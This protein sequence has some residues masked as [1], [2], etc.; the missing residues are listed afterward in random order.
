MDTLPDEL[1]REILIP[2]LHIDEKTFECVFAR[3]PF[4][5]LLQSSSVLL[6]VCKTWMRVATPLLYNT[7]ILRSKAQAYALQRTLRA[8]KRFGSY[9]RK[10]R[11]EGGYG[12]AMKTIL[13]LAPKITHIWLTLDLSGGDNTTGLCNS[14]ALINPERV[15]LQDLSTTRITAPSQKLHT[16]LCDSFKVWTNMVC[17]PIPSVWESYKKNLQRHISLP[18]GWD[19]CYRYLTAFVNNLVGVQNLETIDVNES[20]IF[21]DL[22]TLAKIP[23]L[24]SILIR[25]YKPT[26]ENLAVFEEH[27]TSITRGFSQPPLKFYWDIEDL[28]DID[29]TSEITPVHDSL[30]LPSCGPVSTASKKK[31]ELA[32]PL[33]LRYIIDVN[34]T[35]H[36]NPYEMNETRLAIS[37]V[38]KLFRSLTRS[39]IYTSPIPLQGKGIMKFAKR[40]A[41]EPPLRPLLRSLHFIYPSIERYRQEAQEAL[42]QIISFAPALQ[43]ISRSY[44]ALG[45]TLG[46]SLICLRDITLDSIECPSI[47]SLFSALQII[48]IRVRQGLVIDI[49]RIPK[50]ALNNIT[51]LSLDVWNSSVFEMFYH[52]D[53]DALKH[54]YTVHLHS[55]MIPFLEKH[56]PK[57]SKL[58]ITNVNTISSNIFDLCPNLVRVELYSELGSIEAEFFACNTTHKLLETISMNLDKL[59]RVTVLGLQKAQEAL[60]S[61]DLSPFTALREFQI[62]TGRWPETELEIK[63]NGW[64]ICADSLLRS[65]PGVKVTNLYGKAWRTRLQYSNQMR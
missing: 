52:M 37:L 36:T 41:E 1:I 57:L 53:L 8:N 61:V 5:S 60:D 63:K 43:Q 42:R 9:I 22:Q 21:S 35:G 17:P 15:T 33:I 49:D 13:S 30:I 48:D 6:C 34:N 50:Q 62:P 3:S 25:G 59:S 47:F 58:M 51:T 38:C 29:E 32:W 28:V 11:V 46:A 19:G 65:N 12:G 10:I 55:G 2:L 16:K 39:L 18:S 7:V 24:K 56:G 54:F 45:E 64:V 20:V 44:S 40:L 31:Q 23:S 26:G 4:A 14:L 27:V